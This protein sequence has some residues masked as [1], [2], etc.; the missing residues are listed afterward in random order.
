[1]QVSVGVLG[2]PLA[3]KPKVVEPDGCS[4]PLY[5]ALATDTEEPLVLSVPLHTWVMF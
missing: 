5:A 4:E 2:V 3:M 1:M